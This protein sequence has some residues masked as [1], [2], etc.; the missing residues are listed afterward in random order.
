MSRSPCA[1]SVLAGAA[2][3]HRDD[4]RQGGNS[5]ATTTARDQRRGARSAA[6]LSRAGGRDRQH[7]K[8]ALTGRRVTRSRGTDSST[9]L[10]LRSGVIGL[11]EQ[12]HGA[13][14]EGR[15]VG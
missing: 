7:A 15:A 9:R 4:L 10:S 1:A 13:G 6:S 8:G 12:P 3:F 14:V 11:K 5:G 2:L